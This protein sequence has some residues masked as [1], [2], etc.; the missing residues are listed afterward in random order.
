M[1]EQHEAPQGKAETEQENTVA[2]VSETGDTSRDQAETVISEASEAQSST[3]QSS[4]V[5]S[6]PTSP[7]TQ[8]EKQ[9]RRRGGGRLIAG[10]ALILV[11]ISGAAS[12]WIHQ[13]LVQLEN[14][15]ESSLQTKL[16]QQLTAQNEKVTQQLAQLNAKVLAAQEAMDQQVHQIGGE[17][18]AAQQ[19]RQQ[20]LADVEQ[21]LVT[22][23]AQDARIEAL[24]ARLNAVL[25]RIEQMRRAQQPRI[26]LRWQSAR[27]LLAVGRVQA[28]NLQRYDAA[29]E[30]YQAARELLLEQVGE[31]T[32]PVIAVL[33]EEIRL[34]AAVPQVDY[35]A[36]ETRVVDAM[37][38]IPDW[39]PTTTSQVPTEAEEGW[40]DKL[41]LFGRRAVAIRRADALDR[42][43]LD[44]LQQALRLHLLAIQA[45]LVVADVEAITMH[46]SHGQTLIA[47]FGDSL[48]GDFMAIDKLFADLQAQRFSVQPP[49]LGQAEEKLNALLAARATEVAE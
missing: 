24:Q 12:W 34:L 42:T 13:R 4:A 48:P 35:S 30:H 22:V 46:A 33:D 20:L 36:L 15:T 21:R 1:N 7:E 45:G 14:L 32:A 19:S 16:S 27:D 5:Q 41:K 28:L 25:E 10:L 9:S 39:I 40:W 31:Q 23:D 49:L 11:I 37:A 17:L 6:S 47:Q 29:I 3:A 18:G 43:G 44:V 2:E 38:M 8:P 26:A